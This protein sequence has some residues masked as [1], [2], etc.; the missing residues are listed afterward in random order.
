MNEN[1]VNTYNF[2]TLYDSLLL[3][4]SNKN[5]IFKIYLYYLDNKFNIEIKDGETKD[6]I[7]KY[8]FECSID[9]YN[10]LINIIGNEFIDNHTITLPMFK[11]ITLNDSKMYYEANENFKNQLDYDKAKIHVIR[12][13]IFE[14]RVYYFNGL[15][16]ISYEMQDKA[17]LK[18]NQK[19]KVY[20]KN[21]L[22]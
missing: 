18:L 5:R 20:K 16:S 3:N 11:D 8:N 22:C 13:S 7:F 9:E 14:L 1:D 6:V 17:M 12:N 4:L 21:L 15:N 10:Q 2:L 19:D